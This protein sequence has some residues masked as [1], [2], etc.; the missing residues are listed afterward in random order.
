MSSRFIEEVLYHSSLLRSSGLL[1][2]VFLSSRR[3]GGG[4]GFVSLVRRMLFME[5]APMMNMWY[6]PMI[7]GLYVAVPLL[8]VVI[9]ALSG[10]AFIVPGA[11]ILVVGFVIPW[12]NNVL[13]VFGIT[14]ILGGGSVLDL[15]F[16]GGIYG[17]YLALG[18]FIARQRVLRRIP[19]FL[20]ALASMLGFAVLVFVQ[21]EA[22][23]SGLSYS[24]W[25]N[26]LFILICTVFLFELALRCKVLTKQSTWVQNASRYSFAVFFLHPLFLTISVNYGGG[27]I[28]QFPYTLS[29]ATLFSVTL[30]LSYLFAWLICRNR[31]AGSLVFNIKIR[32][33]RP[34]HPKV[35]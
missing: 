33:D 3:V 22:K 11:L 13:A 14:F 18:Y 32:G 2:I 1:S 15:S 27:W 23:K 26:D 19:T 9:R 21:Y 24:I 28:S 35:K 30:V 16:V 25:Y 34:T 12:L 31:I 17:L 10:K 5:N 29:V 6:M 7:L 4:M 20:C 8:S